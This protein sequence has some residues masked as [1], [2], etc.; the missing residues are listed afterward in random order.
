VGCESGMVAQFSTSLSSIEPVVSDTR[1]F[2]KGA[3]VSA[4]VHHR[5]Q[6]VNQTQT[7][8]VA[9][10]DGVIRVWNGWGWSSSL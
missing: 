4:M 8:W 2:T 7:V 3:G 6:D 10:V 5:V 1:Q 9:S